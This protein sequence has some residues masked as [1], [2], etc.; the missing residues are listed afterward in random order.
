MESEGF[1]VNSGEWWH[2]D[3][4]DWSEYDILDVTFEEL[5]QQGRAK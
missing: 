3:Y 5:I 4:R 1:R 2:F